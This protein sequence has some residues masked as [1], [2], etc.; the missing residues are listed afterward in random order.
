MGIMAV[1]VALLGWL[2]IAPALDAFTG[3]KLSERYAK[4]GFSNRETIAQE[5]LQ[6]FVGH[7]ILGVGPGMGKFMRKKE[8]NSGGAAHTEFTRLLSEHGMLGVIALLALVGTASYRI[9]AR[10][11]SQEKA[12]R[13]TAIAYSFL[14]MAVTA[15]RVALPGFVFGLAFINFA[16]PR[17]RGAI[18]K[19]ASASET[20]VT[21]RT[22]AL[23]GIR[24]MRPTQ[25]FGVWRNRNSSR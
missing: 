15:M 11:T 12:L 13:A 14:F 5:D 4:K 19:S 20:F 23:A 9:M 18:A 8:F 6:L 1:F 16:I 10:G 17:H 21:E 3:G 22:P 25:D 7:P 2:L 24:T